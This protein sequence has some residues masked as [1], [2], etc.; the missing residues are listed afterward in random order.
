MTIALS[1]E[2]I[3]DLCKRAETLSLPEILRACETVVHD[4][5]AAA[6]LERGGFGT[7]Q[8]N[9][10]SQIPRMRFVA[11]DECHLVEAARVG[12]TMVVRAASGN[13][14]DH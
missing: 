8:L 13:A 7:L 2:Q 12:P 10:P 9:E 11:P 4:N 5:L 6:L 3:G 1:S 14:G